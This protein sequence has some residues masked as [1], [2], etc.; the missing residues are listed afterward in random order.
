MSTVRSI[1]GKTRMDIT[2]NQGCCV[3]VSVKF[4]KTRSKNSITEEKRLTNSSQSSDLQDITLYS[5]TG[6]KC[7]K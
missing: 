6:Y 5:R 1:L 3:T 7:G 2:P 4:I